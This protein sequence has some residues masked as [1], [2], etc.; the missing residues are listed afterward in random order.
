MAVYSKVCKSLSKNA[1]ETF[2]CM[3]PLTACVLRHRQIDLRTR[4]KTTTHYMIYKSKATVFV[5][6]KKSKRRVLFYF[7]TLKNMSHFNEVNRTPNLA[8]IQKRIFCLRQH[9]HRTQETRL[10]LMKLSLISCP[11]TFIFLTRGSR[12]VYSMAAT[13]PD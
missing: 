6:N 4:Y 13:N 7:L 1:L 10:Y 2:S 9:E 11:R 8:R 12:I 5:K 3:R